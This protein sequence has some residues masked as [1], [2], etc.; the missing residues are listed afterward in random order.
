MNDWVDETARP[1]EPV[2]QAVR[3]PRRVLAALAAF[4][5]RRR[6]PA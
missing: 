1:G 6:T 5:T 3:E 2:N 4:G